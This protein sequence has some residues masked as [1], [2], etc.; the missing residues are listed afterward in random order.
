MNG[1]DSSCG[2]CLG[3][4]RLPGMRFNAP[5]HPAIDYR[6]GDHG[7]FK[8][9]MLARL[10]STQYPAL[11]AL[12][13]RDDD[14][15]SVAYC[16][17]ASVMLD[18]LSFYQERIAN[19]NY[20][21]T[22]TERRSVAELARLIGYQPSPGVAAA[23][24]LAFTL[25]DAPG[26][27]SLAAQPVTIP[28]GTRAQSVPGAEEQPQTFET[29]AAA[30]AR[31]EWNAIPAQTTEAQVL[32]AGTREIFVAGSATQIQAGDAVLIVGDERR[33]D[34][35]STRWDVRI[36]ADVKAD[37]ALERTCIV[38]SEGMSLNPPER[39]VRVFA[40][41]QRASLFG[42]NAADPRLLNPTGT[43]AGLI[44]ATTMEWLNYAIGSET[45]DLDGSFPKVQAGSWAV[46][47]GGDGVD[48]SESLP[49]RI[50]VVRV[51]RVRQLSL[52]AF[53]LSGKA[54]R[55]KPDATSNLG[56]FTRRKSV[57]FAQSEELQ[58]VPRPLDQPLYGSALALGRR[59][60]TLAEGQWLAISGR[61]QR[62]R[63]EGDD[64]A[65]QFKPDGAAAVSVRPGDQFMLYA[66]PTW[67]LPSGEAALP[68]ATLAFVLRWKPWLPIRWRV[69]DRDGRR[70]TL[71]A[72]PPA[73]ALAPSTKD[74]AIV[75]ELAQIA[76]LPTAIVHGRDHT[77]LE[78]TSP[79]TEVYDRHS[80]TVCANLV[81]AT[82]GE[83]VAEVAGS[84]DA[85]VANQRFLLKQSPLTWIGADTP[86]GR[87]STLE[88]R[89]DGQLWQ[90]VPS[91]FGRGA[92]ERVYALR[93]DDDQRTV[94]QFGDGREGAR[95]SSGS[96]NIRLAYRRG[97]GTAG[98]VRGGQISTLLGRPLGVKTVSNPVAASGGQDRESR[99]D[100]RRNA[101]LTV[102]TLGRL[103][104][105]TDYT[106]FARAFA[107]IDRATAIW[108][109][110]GGRRSVHV[111]VAG[112]SGATLLP[113]SDAATRLAT[114]MRRYGDALVPLRI[115]T[116]RAA[117]FRIKA[118]IKVAGDAIATEV[119]T[120][121]AAALRTRYAFVHRDFD[122]H[123]SVDQVMAAIHAVRG[124]EAADL[125]LLHRVG[126]GIPIQLQ[127]R[128]FAR[129]AR[130][131]QDG[132]VLGAEIL[133][134][135]AD[136]LTLEPMP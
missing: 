52:S 18:V 70:G 100:A 46:L 113:G 23:V 3:A 10:S 38:L 110:I 16:D 97:L 68:P 48:G 84:G 112:A 124:V 89:V 101:P 19:E 129:P 71:D 60:T 8:A 39:R 90:P 85:S 5:G 53:G 91:L 118:K 57:V 28:I 55:I 42:H 108:M 88:V 117:T 33:D 74:D 65:L 107:G 119:M 134:L 80:L 121:V 37:N 54:T 69:I 127:P 34:P 32:D 27:P 35:T 11:G 125:D 43:V 79:L 115:D 78:L 81:R 6:I 96:D 76:A 123:V 98:N 15:F 9:A 114:A 130:L 14:D 30:A 136:G 72:K 25:E 4:E 36:V 99:D 120:A 7:S 116:Y 104:S 58:L 109:R 94:L 63:V 87:A 131:M 62:L 20:L 128:L 105:I 40:M 95:P 41:R 133:T 82:H 1:S 44:D 26:Q 31:V 29:V 51:G 135:A 21:R 73:V 17:A 103:V 59:V 102:L 122:Q 132:S 106:D 67:L 66:A 92:D 111:S 49:G 24:H 93:S 86:S 64:P 77:L 56:H 75:T 2:C 47:C 50:E 61:R 12:R 83:S 22:A 13:T 45:F 126:P